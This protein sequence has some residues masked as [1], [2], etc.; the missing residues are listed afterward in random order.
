MLFI[1]QEQ[2]ST[3]TTAVSQQSCLLMWS[4]S[5]KRLFIPVHCFFLFNCKP[6]VTQCN[7]NGRHM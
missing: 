4:C 7:S 5:G 3:N 2:T 1:V 6:F